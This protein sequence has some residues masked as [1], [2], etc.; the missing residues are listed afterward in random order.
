MLEIV[1]LSPAGGHAE[2]IR[3]L[4]LASDVSAVVW[5]IPGP[6]SVPPRCTRQDGEAIAPLAS[7]RLTRVD[8]GTRIIWIMRPRT[9]MRLVVSAGT[10]GPS[11]RI[12][13]DPADPFIGADVAALVEDLDGRARI[14][15]LTALLTSWC[16]AFRLSRSATYAE[17]IQLLASELQP[18]DARAVVACRPTRDTAIVEF[19]TTADLGTVSSAHVVTAHGVRRLTVEA[20]ARK[21]D[22]HGRRA[23]VLLADGDAAML[24]AGTLVLI[25]EHGIAIRTLGQATK[26]PLSLL[27]W[28]G[29]RRNDSALTEFLVRTLSVRSEE[30]RLAVIDM[31]ARAA[32]PAKATE[33]AA[34]QPGAEVDL[35]LSLDGGLLVGGWF[36]DPQGLIAGVD[37]VAAGATRPI[38]ADWHLFPGRVG[39]AEGTTRDDATGFI[40]YLPHDKPAGPILQPRFRLRLKS[41]GEISLIPRPQPI[42]A[43]TMRAGALRAV[44]LQHATGTVLSETLGPALAEIQRRV[45][46]SVSVARTEHFGP[47]LAE[48]MFSIIVPLY[49]VLDFLRFQIAAFATDPGLRDQAEIIFV[50]DSPEQADDVSHLLGGL[51]RLYQMPMTLAVMSGNGGYAR[52]NNAGVELARG[53]I[54]NLLNSDVIPTGHDWLS[55][56]SDRLGGPGKVGAIGPK[57]LFEDGSLQHAGL[58]FQRDARGTWLNH[59]FYKGMPGGHAPANAARPVPAVTGACLVMMRDTFQDVGG[60]TEDYVIGDYEDSDICLKIRATGQAIAYEPGVALYHLERRSMRRNG[61]YMRGIAS[62]YNS[63]LHSQRWDGVIGSLMQESFERPEPGSSTPAGSRRSAA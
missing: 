35:A 30:A 61:D 45:V 5:D 42:D 53:L 23:M 63:W 15:L 25:G 29:A 31:Q 19:A 51:Y 62:R 55:R 39:S 56:L 3:S 52:A 32:V 12:E 50:L 8:G 58:Y 2:S 6:C 36:R 24:G 34:F 10:L 44:P 17:A 46:A 41:G 48:P 60:F 37:H 47:R 28:W 33:L 13:V 7:L 40:A 20:H 1:P 54:V 22:S 11:E 59:H 16:G 49:R 38:E 18:G 43:A 26:A 21:A 4:K 9:S 14:S 27:R 57:L